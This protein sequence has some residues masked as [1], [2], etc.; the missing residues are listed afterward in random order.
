MAAARPGPVGSSASAVRARQR[1][2]VTLKRREHMQERMYFWSYHP[3]TLP[4]KCLVVGAHIVPDV[5]L[6]APKH[7]KQGID[8]ILVQFN[9][10]AQVTMLLKLSKV[11]DPNRCSC[12][13]FGD[14]VSDV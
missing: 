8:M 2:A 6:V 3:R 11:L 4:G 7:G 14:H 10:I 12:I 1:F 13:A 9:L 5:W